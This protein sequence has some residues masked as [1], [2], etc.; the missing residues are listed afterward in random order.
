MDDAMRVGFGHRFTRLN[1]IERGIF[2]AQYSVSLQ[3][4]REVRLLEVHHDH[5]WRTVFERT[6]IDH[7]RAVNALH[8]YCYAILSHE[9]RDSL[10][11]SDILSKLETDTDST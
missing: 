7:A 11:V 4:L 8:L 2:D 6:N 10:G 5:V 9:A 3:D 1:D